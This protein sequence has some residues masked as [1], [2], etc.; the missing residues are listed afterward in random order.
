MCTAC[1]SETPCNEIELALS[2]FS[3]AQNMFSTRNSLRWQ[4][5]AKRIDRWSRLTI[6]AFCLWLAVI[7][8]VELDDNYHVIGVNSDN[9]YMF[10]GLAPVIVL[11]PFAIAV[12]ITTPVLLV[13]IVGCAVYDRWYAEAMDEHHPRR[14]KQ[15][16][17]D[18]M[19]KAISDIE[20]EAASRDAGGE[21]E[22]D[23]QS[24]LDKQRELREC[25][26]Q[27]GGR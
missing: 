7:F 2:N 18:R 16:L 5:I 8:N 4:R 19:K 17:K 11:E 26:A 13:L 21:A 6:V 9:Q 20:S 3:I 15:S 1:L 10:S 25:Q 12:L 24:Y 23:Q 14:V 22:A 27:M